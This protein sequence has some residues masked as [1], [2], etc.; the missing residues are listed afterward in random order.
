MPTWL[1]HRFWF[2][3]DVLWYVFAAGVFI[4]VTVK[5]KGLYAS[6]KPVPAWCFALAF[7]RP[8]TPK[9]DTLAFFATYTCT[10]TSVRFQ[11][12]QQVIHLWG[13]DSLKDRIWEYFT[14]RRKVV[15]QP[16]TKE[17]TGLL[18]GSCVH[19]FP[20]IHAKSGRIEWQTNGTRVAE[21][22]PYPQA[23]EACTTGSGTG[24]GTGGSWRVRLV[25]S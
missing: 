24:G 3:M 15:I 21:N 10:A 4:W 7:P 22:Y 9:P 8:H 17:F 18:P 19:A 12:E 5:R 16:G 1:Q 2:G 23:L 20:L 14:S 6:L 13:G 25:W 11:W